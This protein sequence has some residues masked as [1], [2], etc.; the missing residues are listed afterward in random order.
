MIDP[1]SRFLVVRVT[2]PDGY[3][4][5]HYFFVL[6]VPTWTKVSRYMRSPARAHKKASRYTRMY[7]QGDHFW[8]EVTRCDELRTNPDAVPSI[9]ER[10][11]KAFLLSSCYE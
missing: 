3:Q 6:H 9:G 11:A 8:P 4:P 5:G 2:D 7:L 1:N 10:L